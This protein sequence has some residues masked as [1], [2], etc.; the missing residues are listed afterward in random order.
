MTSFPTRAR[1]SRRP[2]P[3]TYGPFGLNTPDPKRAR[4][5][6]LRCASGGSL[7]PMAWHL[8]E[9]RFL[10]IEPSERQAREGDWGHG[11]PL[12]CALLWPRREE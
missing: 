8:L 1:R 5:L 7:T 6:E 2:T 10:G 12:S 3:G 11:P 4:V 9:A